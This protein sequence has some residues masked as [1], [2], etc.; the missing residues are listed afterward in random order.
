MYDDSTKVKKGRNQRRMTS[1]K[2]KKLESLPLPMVF[3]HHQVLQLRRAWHPSFRQS[4]RGSRRPISSNCG[5][6]PLRRC[7]TKV[8][9]DSSILCSRRNRRVSAVLWAPSVSTTLAV[10]SVHL[11]QCSGRS[12]ETR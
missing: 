10:W 12:V 4:P 3:K 7:E 11:Y 8:G 5:R 6:H 9:T 1:K 2:K